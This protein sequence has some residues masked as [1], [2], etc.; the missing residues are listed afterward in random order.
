LAINLKQILGDHADD[1]VSRQRFLLEAEITGGLEHPGIVP[2][3]GL[4]PYD[5]GRPN[6]AM[7]LIRGDSLKEAIARFHGG[8]TSQNDPG[9]RS[10]ELRMLIRRFLDVCNAMNRLIEPALEAICLKAMALLP[11]DRYGSPRGLADDLERWAADEPVSGGREP[12]VERTLRWMRRRRSTVAAVAAATAV[13]LFGLAAVLAVQA[14][15]NSDLTSANRS[16]AAASRRESQ[17][18]RDLVAA[19]QR[20]RTWTIQQALADAEPYRGFRGDLARTLDNIAWLQFRPVERSNPEPY[21]AARGP[22]RRR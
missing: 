16:L 18:N 20:E 9:I 7:R 2:V 19:N 12:F 10:L 1:P 14:Q 17:A 4:G 5:D 13:A 22:C 6:Y 8:A 21:S 11:E 15:A 3:Y